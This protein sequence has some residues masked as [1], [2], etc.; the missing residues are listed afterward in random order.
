[1]FP[2]NRDIE[3]LKGKSLEIRRLIIQMLAEAGSGHPGGS[4]SSAD[5]LTTL[6]YA[7]LKHDPAWPK[8]PDRDRFVLSKGH[9]CPLLYA[10]LAEAGYFDKSELMKLRKIG[11]MLQGHPSS[12]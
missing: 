12:C 7:V 10:I 11:A 5:T 1:M 9:C 4:L 6:F 8:W 3:F 2:H